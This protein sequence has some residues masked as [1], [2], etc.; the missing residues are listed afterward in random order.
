MNMKI[1][2][3]KQKF[4]HYRG[5]K[6]K[7][8]HYCCDKLK[9]STVVQLSD[10]CPAESNI[11]DEDGRIPQ[12]M[13]HEF[14]IINSYGDEWQ[15]DYYYP[16]RFCPFCGESIKIKVIST[17]DKTEYYNYLTKERAE[18]WKRCQ[19][20]DSKTEEQNLLRKRQELDDLID[21]L[22]D[23]AEYKEEQ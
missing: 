17:E 22:Y 19:E 16:I 2:L 21:N 1:E 4:D 5:Y 12:M 10:E 20:T 11:C 7:P 9:E 6:Y 23:F 18:V 3:I 14:E 15:A 8:L 13:L